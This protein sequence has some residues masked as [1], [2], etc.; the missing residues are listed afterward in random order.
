MHITESS[1][2]ATAGRV[3]RLFVKPAH[4]AQMRALAPG[5]A[6]QCIEGLG[7]A[8]D[9]HANRLSPRQVLVTLRCELDALS[10][11][12]GALH[13][14]LVIALASPAAF[15][16]GA[17]L[18]TARGV[19][20]WLT[21]YCEPCQRIAAVAPDLA[22]MVQRRGILGRIVAGGAIV[23]G[24]MLELI[25]GRHRALPASTLQMFLDVVAAIPA[26]QVARYRDVTTAMG[27][28]DSFVRAIP[29]YIRR[30]AAAGLAC[31]RIVDAK[32]RL[33]GLVPCQQQLLEG[34]GV[35]VNAGAVDLER[36]LWR[37]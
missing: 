1:G 29:G 36:V 5:E 25:P 20:I 16:P 8:G 30:N 13:E 24:D 10:L 15:R 23:A 28:A 27:V 35:Q 12:A 33:P 11:G 26:G 6:L 14:N 7:I 37:G 32:G 17:A 31:H 19:E 4:G 3:E 21:M 34:E 22:A 2:R 9:V 18:V